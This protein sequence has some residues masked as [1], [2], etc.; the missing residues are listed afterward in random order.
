MSP[1]LRAP[2]R[3]LAAASGGI[4]L[5]LAA[6]SPAA[7]Q[8]SVSLTGYLDAAV[9]AG[10]HG[11]RTNMRSLGASDLVFAGTEDLGGGLRATFR[12]AHRFDFDTGSNTSRSFFHE[13]ST[14][15]LEGGF[16]SFRMGRALSAMWNNDWRFDPWY[17]FDR[18]ASPAWQLWHGLSPSSP[19]S[20]NGG[21]V[22]TQ[23]LAHEFARVNNALL[24]TSPSLGGFKLDLSYEMDKNELDPAARTRNLS[25]VVLYDA[26][27]PFTAMLAAERNGQDNKTLFGAAKYNFGAFALMG[28]YEREKAPSGT[29]YFTGKDSNRTAT[30]AGTYTSGLTTFKLGYGRQLDTH[31]NYFSAGVSHALSKRTNLVFSAGHF[32]KKL[33]GADQAQ[34]QYAVGMNHSF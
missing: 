24:Y 6:A 19:L 31:A 8:S 25:A 7:A 27:G 21:P 12:L 20:P 2:L 5:T 30:L 9:I 22:G 29:L 23:G 14:V 33:W 10:N 26:G 15:G 28:A 11:Y 34:T 13:E 18:V 32:G 1:P 3:T 17:N 4:V 16:G